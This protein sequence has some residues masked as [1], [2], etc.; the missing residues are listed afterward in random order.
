MSKIRLLWVTIAGL[1]VINLALLLFLFTHNQAQML[2]HGPGRRPEG[3]KKIIKE[4]LHFDEQ[5]A[6]DYEKLIVQ[7][8][9]AIREL[10]NDIASTRT[11]LYL[12]LSDTA[13]SGKDSLQN[14]LGELQQQIEDVHYNHFND[15]RKLCRSDQLSGFSALTHDLAGYFTPEKNLPPPPKD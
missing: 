11:S 9:K 1:I 6:A 7:H 13:R 8:R 2:P 15:I 12:T 14:R 3:P 5:Q 4:R 10:E